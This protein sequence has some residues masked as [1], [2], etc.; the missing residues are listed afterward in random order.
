MYVDQ[1]EGKDLKSLDQIFEE[2]NFKVEREPIMNPKGFD[3]GFDTIYKKNDGLNL[4]VVS[5]DYKL[6]THEEALTRVIT[7]LEKKKLPKIKPVRLQMTHDG[8]RMYAEFRLNKKSDIGITPVSNH[9]VGDMIAPGFMITNSYDRSLKLSTKSYI[10]RLVCSNGMVAQESLFSERKRHTKGLNLDSVVEK[11]V[12]SFERFD[13]QIVPQVAALTNQILSPKDLEEEL[14][15][16][17][18]WI[19]EEAINYLEKGNWLNLEN[20]NFEL[21]KDI[22]K[23]DLLNSFTYVMSHSLTTNPKTAME[24]NQKISE[25]FLG[26]AA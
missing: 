4:G 16:I 23:W 25:R 11:F 10:Y 13:E 5:R 14:N 18:S 12:E 22:T 21:I 1:L 19:Q 6:I 15:S 17:P 8:S 26:N 7:L 3:T 2:V 24:L 9:K 20:D